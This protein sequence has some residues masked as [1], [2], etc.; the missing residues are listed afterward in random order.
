VDPQTLEPKQ[1]KGPDERSTL[2]V[3]GRVFLWRR[4][5]HSKAQ[6]TTTPSDDLLDAFGATMSLA[7]RDLCVQLNRASRSFEMTAQNL[8]QA[9]QLSL[10]HETVRQ[11][12]EGDGKA[13]LELE[14]LGE[15]HPTWL[16]AQCKGPDGK[17]LVYV[18]SDGFTAPT[19]THAEKQARRKKVME[20]RENHRKDSNAR[21]LRRLPPA[22][23]GTDQRYKEFK[24]VMFFDHSLKHRQLSVTRDDCNAAGKLMIRD[25]G[26][27]GFSAADQRVGLIDGGPWI[28]NQIQKRGLKVTAVGLDFYHLGENVHK[29]RRIVFGPEDAAGKKAADQLMHTV[30]HQGYEPMREQ[31]LELRQGK[32]AA[33]RKEVDRLIEY[34]SDRRQMIRYPQ[35]IAAG[36]H[37]GSGAM[38]SECRVL[39]DRVKGPGKRWDTDNAEAVMAL[40]A[41]Y[42]SGR[43]QEYRKWAMGRPN[44]DIPKN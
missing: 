15:L 43:S 40:E 23:K 7:T 42:Q 33:K 38:E 17:S 2:S 14:R 22:K 21:T 12:V 20:K 30:K 16:A 1:N 13:V 41:L 35:F 27:L 6:G 8:K 28:I 19:I 24:A 18:S 36:W 32:R 37:I 39:P 25:A 3:N 4:H 34:V 11:A 10:S 9:A 44:E 26:R 5:Y 31:L 29:T